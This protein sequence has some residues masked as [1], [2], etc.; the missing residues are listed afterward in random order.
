MRALLL[1]AAL[2]AAP[3]AMAQ[4]APAAPEDPK[5]TLDRCIAKTAISALE[6]CV[7]ATSTP[8]QN[9]EGG[10][11]TLGQV[12]CLNVERA[13]WEQHLAA[14]TTDLLGDLSKPSA[15]KLATAQKAWAAWRDAKCAFDATVYEGGSLARVVM[16]HCLMR[17]T[18]M[19]TV[20]LMQRQMGAIPED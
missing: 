2:T 12:A 20:T 11:T 18:G 3:V 16:A 10:E 13:L 9:T 5:Q 14:V 1:I 7:G 19:R 15:A 6:R 17:E 8:C 4:R